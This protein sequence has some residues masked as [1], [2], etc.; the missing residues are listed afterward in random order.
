MIKTEVIK[1]EFDD[2]STYEVTYTYDFEGN[3]VDISDSDGHHTSLVFYKG[4]AIKTTYDDGYV[5]ERVYMGDTVIYFHD[6][7]GYWFEKFY[8]EQGNLVEIK[9]STD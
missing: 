5:V 4:K 6:S 2:G 1:H 7:Y 8:D 3:L 9:E